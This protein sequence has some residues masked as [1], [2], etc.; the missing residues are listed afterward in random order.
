MVTN[1]ES[2]QPPL[3]EKNILISETKINLI[4][5]LVFDKM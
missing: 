2:F 1:L 3:P 4:F 5:L